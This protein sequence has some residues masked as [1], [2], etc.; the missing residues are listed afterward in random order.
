MAV[1]MPAALVVRFITIVVTFALA[2]RAA[3]CRVLLLTW[4][5]A[6]R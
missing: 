2:R 4:L 5:G 3:A 6:R 1:A